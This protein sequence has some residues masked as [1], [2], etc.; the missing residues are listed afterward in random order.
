MSKPH[1]RH[2]VLIVD[3][4]GSMDQTRTDA[5]GG[6]RAFLKEQ[7]KAPGD[8]T[9]TLVQFDTLIETVYEHRPLAEVPDYRLEPRSSTALL[10]AIGITVARESGRI[11]SAP[12]EERPDEVVVVIQTDGHENASR[13]YTPDGIRAL[14]ERM[15]QP[16]PGWVFVFLGADQD[17]IK[18]GGR[19]GFRAD[20]SMSYSGRNTVDSLKRAGTMVARGSETGLYGFTDDERRQAMPEGESDQ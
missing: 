17:A 7:A 3:R 12:E 4:S 5:E 16:D 19:M 6:L 2:I 15:Q 10:D 14:I 9:V 11:R 13:E 1:R 8:T 18:A 20:T